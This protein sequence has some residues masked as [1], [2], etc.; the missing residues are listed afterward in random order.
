[1]VMMIAG[2]AIALSDS[3]QCSDRALLRINQIMDLMLL[4]NLGP[5]ALLLSY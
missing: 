5:P 1:M 3:S 2:S 4:Y